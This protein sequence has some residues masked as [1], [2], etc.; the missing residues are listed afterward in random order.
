MWKRISPAEAPGVGL[1][2]ATQ[3]KKHLTVYR[4]SPSAPGAGR[5]D[6]KHAFTE[7][8]SRAA[9]DCAAAG[10]PSRQCRTAKVKTCMEGKGLFTGACYRRSKST[11]APFAGMKYKLACGGRVGTRGRELLVTAR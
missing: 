10:D 3:A 6:V 8:A 7:C 11:R 4:R 1:I 9:D 2:M 5:P